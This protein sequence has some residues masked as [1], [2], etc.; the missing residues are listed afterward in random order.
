VQYDLVMQPSGGG[1]GTRDAILDAIDHLMARSGFRLT[2]MDEVAREAGCSR[3]AIYTYFPSKEELG[4]SSIDRVVARAHGRLRALAAEPQAPSWRLR[5]MLR[6][7][8]LF[9]IDAVRGYR[10]SLDELFELVR[11]SYMARR[12]RHFAAE[13]MILADVLQQGRACGELVFDDAVETAHTLIRATNAF[14]PYG[15]SVNELGAKR[16]IDAEVS[17]MADL[18]LRGLAAAT[19]RKRTTSSRRKRTHGT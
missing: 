19:S 11:P 16:R 3:R 14:L 8:V 1:T 4:L 9:R 12:R 18:L 2:T 17:R 10:Q 15:L 7:R 6:E 5:A 13:A